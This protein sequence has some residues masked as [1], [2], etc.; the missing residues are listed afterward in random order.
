MI[1]YS[2]TAIS[3]PLSFPYPLSLIPP[4]GDSAAEERP[5]FYGGD[6]GI[7]IHGLA[8]RTT[9]HDTTGSGLDNS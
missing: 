3:L 9:F 8:R 6:G 1:Q 7:S 2:S 5:V 4:K